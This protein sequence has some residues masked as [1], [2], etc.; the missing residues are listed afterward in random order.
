MT[1]SKKTLE[2]KVLKE[3]CCQESNICK[4]F[5][6]ITNIL[7]LFQS[8]QQTQATDIQEDEIKVEGPSQKR[9]RILRSHK[10]RSTLYTENTLGKLTWKP[11]DGVA[12]KDRSRTTI[13][14]RMKLW[15]TLWGILVPLTSWNMASF[16]AVVL[17]YLPISHM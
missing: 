17:S 7:N 13:V 2:Y 14:K 1:L 12:K 6:R 16:F 8:Q 5:K 3:N 11:T 15:N 9:Q 4:I 10:R